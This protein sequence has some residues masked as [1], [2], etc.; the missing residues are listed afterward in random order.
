[1]D[2]TPSSFSLTAREHN[3]PRQPESGV[4][5]CGGV[6]DLAHERS[7][8]MNGFAMHSLSTFGSDRVKIISIGVFALL[9]ETWTRMG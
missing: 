3:R 2:G 5:F 4:S 7:H 9:T 8:S 6:P 1:M